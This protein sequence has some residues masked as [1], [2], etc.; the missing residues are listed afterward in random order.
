MNLLNSSDPSDTKLPTTPSSKIEI[1]FPINEGSLH[2]SGISQE[3]LLIQ[4]QLHHR[5]EAYLCSFNCGYHT[6]RRATVFTHTHKEHFNTMLGCPH[7]DHHIWFTDA[8]VKHVYT[9]HAKLPMFIE[10]KIES[11]TPVESA[12]VLEAVATSKGLT[13][14]SVQK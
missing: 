11:V 8:W 7:C 2:D 9:H 13:V 3:Y 12:E 14:T 6:Q 1:T 5:K 10:M 4:E